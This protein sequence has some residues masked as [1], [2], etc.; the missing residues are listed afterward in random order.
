MRLGVIG[1]GKM[2]AGIARRAASGG[3]EA[4]GFD[5]APGART[6]L[7]GVRVSTVEELAAIPRRLDPPRAVWMMVPAGQPVE[8]TISALT[9]LLDPGDILID[10]GNSNYKDSRQRA[11][12]VKRRDLVYLDVGTSGGIR[13]ESDGYCLMIGG[14]S[15]AVDSLD[16]LWTALAPAPDRGWGHLG[17]SGSGHYA[18]MVHNGIEYGMMQALAE[19]LA[20]LERHPDFDFDLERLTR[21]WNEGS[22]IRSWLVELAGVALRKDP[23]L[24]T[25]TAE[26]ADSGEGRWAVA[27]AI[28][29]NIAAPVLTDALLARLQS[30]DAGAFSNRVLSALR[31]EFGGH[32]AEPRQ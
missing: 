29:L 15:G 22:V 20:L 7:T 25:V 11:E 17:P 19:G 16:W 26:V 3:H 10:G 21:V 27:E 24:E 4:I 9:P 5:F 2:G 28:D 8:D 12:E 30:R 1:L 23:S 18:K 14:E 6:L 31:R 13:G 32:S